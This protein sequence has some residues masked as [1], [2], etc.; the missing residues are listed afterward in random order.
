MRNRFNG[1]DP[2]CVGAAAGVEFGRGGAALAVDLDVPLVAGQYAVARRERGLKAAGCRSLRNQ[3]AKTG[4]TREVPGFFIKNFDIFIQLCSLFY[5]SV[6]FNFLAL[7]FVIKCLLNYFT[8]PS[9]QMGAMEQ[10]L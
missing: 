7:I 5:S 6:V 2:S 1:R 10:Q 3:G 8:V 4:M 9:R